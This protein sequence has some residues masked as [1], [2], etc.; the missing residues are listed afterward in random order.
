MVC[1]GFDTRLTDRCQTPT[2]PRILC[3][4][5]G[6]LSQRRGPHLLI[7]KGD[8]GRVAVPAGRL[9]EVGDPTGLLGGGDVDDVWVEGS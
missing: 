1:H 6:V 5:T 8:A 3:P 4:C 9:P 7:V 2:G